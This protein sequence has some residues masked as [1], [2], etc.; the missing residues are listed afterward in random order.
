M[1]S[2]KHHCMSLG[3]V[4]MISDEK[5]KILEWRYLVI[6]CDI[7][8]LINGQSKTLMKYVY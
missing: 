2:K 4:K 1:L 5:K 7:N 6:L 8:I 3:R